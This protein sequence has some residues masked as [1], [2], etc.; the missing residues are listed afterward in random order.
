MHLLTGLS[1]FDLFHI[2]SEIWVWRDYLKNPVSP[3]LGQILDKLVA[4]D[5]KLRYNRVEPIFKDL[6]K[7]SL[8]SFRPNEKTRLATAISGATIALLSLAIANRVPAPSPQTAL[9]SLE[10]ES[11]Q[12]H[13][14]YQ[15]PKVHSIKPHSSFFLQKLT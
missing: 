5:W 9:K 15:P 13:L 12:P 11:P 4:R 6:K 14:R 3:Q 8:P 2:K 1:A 7:V 10:I